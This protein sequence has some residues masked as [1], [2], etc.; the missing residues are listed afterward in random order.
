M[1]TS[2]IGTISIAFNDI[3]SCLDFSYNTNPDGI[4]DQEDTKWLL[5]PLEP[6]LALQRVRIL[7]TRETG[8]TQVTPITTG[9]DTRDIIDFSKIT[10]NDRAMRRKAEVLKYKKNINNN[11]FSSSYAYFAKSGKSKYR[12]MTNNRI[13]SLLENQKCLNAPPISKPSSN[14]GIFGGKTS[15]ILDSNIEYINDFKTLSSD[16][17]FSLHNMNC[18][19]FVFVWQR[20]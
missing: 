6:Q 5:D 19:I 9:R 7:K 16:N 8:N 1:A 3:P 2:D 14:S 15:L 18:P 11:K 13:K 20:C 4:L 17:D 12:S 10:Y